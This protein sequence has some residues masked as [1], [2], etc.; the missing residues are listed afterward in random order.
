MY[1]PRG[2]VLGG[3]G[4]IN[5]LVY[6][7]GNEGDFDGWAQAGATGWS[8]DDVLP[9]FKKLERYEGDRSELRGADGAIAITVAD[10][11]E[12]LSPIARA[13]FAAAADAGYPVNPDFNGANQEGFGRAQANVF[14]GLRQS[15]SRAYLLPAGKRPNLKIITKAVAT[16]I[17]IKH[18]R[19]C[20]VRYVRRGGQETV[21]AEQEVILAGGAVNSP[22]LLQLSGIGA[23]EHLRNLDIKVTLDL[24]G[25]GE[26][27]QDHAGVMVKQEITKPWSA[28]GYMTP[29]K[30]VVGLTQY[31]LF[32][33]G[34]TTTN[35]LE[36]LAFLKSRPGLTYPDIQYHFVNLLY[37]DHGRTIIQKEGF[38]ANG[39]VA[40]P[41]SRGTVM[42]RSADPLKAPIID[43]RYFSDA[44]D[45]RLAR[46]SIRI[47]RDL[48][49]RH[50]FADFRGQEYA[51]GKRVQ[52]D[53]ELDEFIRETASS[54]YH[55]VGTCRMGK[56]ARAVVDERL[57]VRGIEG[58]R[59]ADASIMPTIVSGNTNAATMMI[60]EKSVDLILE[61]AGA[62]FR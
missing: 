58:L 34:P 2:K 21:H 61:D 48:I 4:S 10:P 47:S 15:S 16:G 19:A 31:A 8:Y 30:Q 18:G 46:E 7:R 56:D 22:Q 44:D 60:A 12:R 29:L 33:S 13:W 54:L 14:N 38:M 6:V 50:P 3:S 1:V 28:L 42:I 27:L 25:V 24:P 32:K 11:I 55:L 62:R 57:R 40:R 37:E 9:Y 53:R 17:E 23:P 26:N 59:I 52:S 45:L 36:L 49:A 35:G 5:G 51:P 39:N 41:A 20:G 43:P